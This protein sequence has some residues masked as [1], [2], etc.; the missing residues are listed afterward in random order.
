MI[1]KPNIVYILADDMGYGDLSC[2]NPSSKIHTPQLDDLAA[3]GMIF[4]DAHASSSVCTPSRYSIL[5]GR[6]NWRSSL[7]S[8][9]LW[10]YS[11][12]LME[13]GRMTVAS[14]LR[15][16]GYYTAVIGKW[17][18]GWDWGTFDE[19]PAQDDGNNVDFGK[20]VENG[21]DSYGFGYSYC[22]SGS[23][24]M[25]PY[26]YVENGSVTAQPDRYTENT[27][28]F[29]WWRKGPTGAD[30]YH[31]DV[32]PNFTRRS[33]KFIEEHAAIGEPFFLYFPLPA[34]HTPILPAPQFQ[35][36]SGTNPYGDFCLQVDDTVG[37]IMKAL[38]NAGIT[39]NTILVFASDNGCSPEV[40]FEQLAGLG[41][42]P[43][44]VFRGAKADIYEGGHR[45]PLIVRW[46]A[47]IRGGSICDETVCLSDLLATCSEIIGVELPDSAGEDSV[48]N[49][50]LW[51]GQKLDSPLREATIHHSIDGSFSIRKGNWKLEMC[52]GSGGWSHPRPGI[53][54]EGL[55]PIQLYDLSVD[56]GER[57]NVAN[58]HP[59][60]V[61]ELTTLLTHYVVN[62]RSTP[63]VRQQNHS[64][65][66]W[67]QLWWMPN[68]SRMASK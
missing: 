45:I 17:H 5:T 16:H 42:R 26:V 1:Q 29:S 20:P 19:K 44:Y 30:F 15:Q 62:G 32:L 37:Q 9:V 36:K 28:K 18:L 53:E 67:D 14:F 35:G 64:G 48:S 52:P 39:Q 57:Q 25:S 12:H 50:A 68:T 47:E 24:D 2:L 8:G 27:E 21:P 46:P 66:D 43:G 7:K 11:R 41:H 33:V 23:L 6:Y 31:A 51:R 54:S 58:S 49:L 10:G 22:I 34:P 63:G 59:E 55:P 61:E 3:Q 56:V 60:I 13:P 65:V 38:E 4:E 40:D